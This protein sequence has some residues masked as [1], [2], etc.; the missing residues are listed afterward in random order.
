MTKHKRKVNIIESDSFMKYNLNDLQSILDQTIL[1]YV[2]ENE[3]IIN[4]EL[5]NMDNGLNKFYIYVKDI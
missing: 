3:I 5:K 1:E 4:I 2:E